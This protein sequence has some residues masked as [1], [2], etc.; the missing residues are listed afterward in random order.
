MTLTEYLLQQEPEWRDKFIHY[1]NGPREQNWLV[2]VYLPVP[3]GETINYEAAVR[4]FVAA[5]EGL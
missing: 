3:E 1:V 2:H 5:L 4:R